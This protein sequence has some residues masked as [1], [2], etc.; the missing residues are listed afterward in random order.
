M[1]RLFGSFWISR[2]YFRTK[3][4]YIQAEGVVDDLTLNLIDGAEEVESR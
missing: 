3:A 1:Q 4:V 2:V